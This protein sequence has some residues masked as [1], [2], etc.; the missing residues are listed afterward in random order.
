MNIVSD[1]TTDAR[2]F[3]SVINDA[4]FSPITGTGGTSVKS[5]GPLYAST[6]AIEQFMLSSFS[7]S[8]KSTASV[9]SESGIVELVY[10]Q[11]AFNTALS[12]G[13]AAVI[14]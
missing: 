4:T 13:T 6:A 12:A 10:W 11:R 3:V 2:S 9:N 8:V 7:V 14:P 5:P 1:G